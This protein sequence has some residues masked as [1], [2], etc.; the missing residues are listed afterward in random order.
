MT[1]TTS[2]ERIMNMRIER[3]LL[4]LLLLVVGACAA[5]PAVDDHD[6]GHDHGDEHEHEHDD[7]GHE[8][9]TVTAW[10][11]L[12]E[13]F[14]EIDE[15]VVGETAMA[16][17]HVT[18]LDGFAALDAGRVEIVFSGD[19]TQIFAADEPDRPGI[20]NIE[21]RPEAEGEFDLAFRIE[22]AAGS[23]TISGGR[24]RVGSDNDP[25]SIRVAPAP[26]GA[27]GGD[28]PMAFGKEQ[29]WQ[30]RFATTWVRVS[31]F[32]R[33][34]DGL[35]TAR[36]VAGGDAWITAPAEGL[37][38]SQPWPFVGQTRQRGQALFKMTPRVARERSLAEL[39]TAVEAAGHELTAAEK[40]VERLETLLAVEATSTREVEDAR[41]RLAVLRSQK[42][43]AEK[44]LSSAQAVRQ[45]RGDGQ[46]LMLNAPFSGSVAVV[47]A[48]PG[49]AVEAGQRLARIVRTDTLWLSVA[50]P[51]RSAPQ[52][53]SGINGVVLS[54]ADG[55]SLRFNSEQSR[56]VS[57]APS[58]DPATG[59]LQVL[60][61]IPGEPGV[62]L[63]STWNAQ[64][65][66]ND[67]EEGTVVPSTAL[68]DDGGQAVVYLQLNGEE[69]VRQPVEVV[70][71]QG[72]EVLVAGLL[73]GQRLVAV[74]G[75]SIRRA[76]LLAT[77]GGGHGHV[78]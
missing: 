5:P 50:L 59:K 12:Y 21:V 77:G 61:E 72:A 25:G 38:N 17:T 34:L 33:A 11:S 69:F 10:G 74:G 27:R 47:E 24:V 56:L 73:P 54:D 51:P 71:R 32:S 48:T 65:L 64:V 16:H 44:N 57:V 8:S 26:R 30:T 13:V 41:T 31:R 62:T 2:M 1:T 52:L 58:V 46:A 18:V 36:P 35:A 45:G 6:H 37:I 22:S 39:E 42:A 14:P 43:A 66:L 23:E 20:F 70:T 4:M 78:H 53:A 68:V 55:T 49:A 60:I 3:F 63:G 29:Q 75:E 76:S 28:E 7:H 9:W 40:R 67:D 15:L 19:T